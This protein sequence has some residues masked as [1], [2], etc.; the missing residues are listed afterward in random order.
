VELVLE[1]LDWL[2]LEVSLWL[3]G[4]VKEKRKGVG[5][6]IFKVID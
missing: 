6:D 3:A 2:M 4:L 1:L 5:V